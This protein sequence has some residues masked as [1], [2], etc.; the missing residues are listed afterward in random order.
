LL[1]NGRMAESRNQLV[2][3]VG[4]HGCDMPQQ[5]VKS[6]VHSGMQFDDTGFGEHA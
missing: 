5:K 3:E 2:L 6:L 1:P 4:G